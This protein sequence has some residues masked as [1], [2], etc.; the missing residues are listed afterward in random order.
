MLSHD[1][2][3]VELITLSA[4]ETV[5][6]RVDRSDNPRGL[7]ASLL[8]AGAEAIVGTLWETRSDVARAFFVELYRS[9]RADDD[10]RAAFRAAQVETRR[11]FPDPWDWGA[12]YYVGSW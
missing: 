8:L 11:R 3:G 12:F 9:L 6:G 7:A 5:L 2:R 4:C 10:R 1:F